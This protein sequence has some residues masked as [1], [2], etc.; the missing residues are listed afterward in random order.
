MKQHEREYFV[1]RIRSGFCMMRERGLNLKILTPTVE[2]SYESAEVFNDAFNKS[3]AE[4]IMDEEDMHLWMREHGLWSDDDDSRVKGLEKDLERLKLEIYNA[5]NDEKK[6]ETIR[7]YIRAGEQQLSEMH[8]KKSAYNSNTCEGIASLEKW[9]W[10]IENCTFLKDNP[11]DF[12][13]YTI[14][15]VLHFYQNNFISEKQIRELARTDPWKSTWTIIEKCEDTLFRNQ[16]RE[17]GSDQKNILIWSI[18]YDNIQESLDCPR[19]DVIED[20]DMLDGWLISQRK[21]NDKDRAEAEFEG[22]TQNDKI[23][24]SDEIFVMAGNDKDKERVEGL[25][26]MGAMMM[27]K[28]R[29]GILIKNLKEGSATEQSEFFDEK[30]KMRRRSNEQYKGKFRG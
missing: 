17:L 10:L 8:I 11:Y 13:E 27:K 21:K 5:R 3:Y 16:G 14:D 15:Y 22:S 30:L 19:D 4:E 28:Q 6:R 18:M 24:N 7:L 1:S 23:K 2:Q 25:N 26:D 29:E 12:E 9:K 20:D